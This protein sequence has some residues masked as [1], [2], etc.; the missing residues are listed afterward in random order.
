M[1]VPTFSE[2]PVS[3]CRRLLSAAVLSVCSL[4]SAPASAEPVDLRMLYNKPPADWPAPELDEGIA[5]RELGLLPAM[6]APGDTPALAD[7]VELGKQ[8]FFDPRLSGSGQIACASCHDPQLGWGDGRRTAIGHDRQ[9][10]PRNSQSLLNI[11]YFEPLFWDGRAETLEEQALQ[12]VVDPLEMHN[13]LTEAEATLNAIPGYR[14]AF[15]EV[16]GVEAIERRQIAQALAAFQRTV[17]SRQSRFDRFL[18]GE[19]DALTDQELAGLHLF[20]TK[21]RCLNCHNGPEFSDRKFH[22]LGL[23][24]FGRSLEDLGR[25]EITGR[26]EDVGAFRTPGLRDVMFTGPWMHNGLFQEMD[27]ILRMYNAGMPR[28]KPRA[29]HRDNP[30]FPTTSPLLKP[31]RLKPEELTALKAFLGSISTRPRLIQPPTLPPA[32]R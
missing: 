26:P 13:T 24:F 10:G 14:Q 11:G 2:S 18:E 31:L 12:P 3:G 29:E 25:Y 5:L 9:T 16:F 7:R 17:V 28:P 6:A 20:R 4:L 19:Q 15:R 32:S 23:H 8:L 30:L 21:A 22:N 1:I 27:S